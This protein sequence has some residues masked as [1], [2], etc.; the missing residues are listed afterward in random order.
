MMLSARRFHHLVNVI[1]DLLNVLLLLSQLI[2]QFQQLSLLLI[3]DPLLLARLF[4]AGKG[5]A[6]F[7]AAHAA[8]SAARVAIGHER[9]GGREGSSC[10]GGPEGGADEEGSAEHGVGFARG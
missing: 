9:A 7:R 5:V 4:A 6:C 10:R 1:L 8:A 2:L 3:L